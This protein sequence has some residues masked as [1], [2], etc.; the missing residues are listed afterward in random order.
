VS[1]VVISGGTDGIGKGIAH[2][3]LTRGDTV[4]IIGRDHGK[5]TDLL[6]TAG[7]H[8]TR[9]RAVF[10]PADLSLVSENRRV[11][12]EI[13]AA[14]PSID[15]LVLCARHYQSARTETSE[16]FEYNF[17]LLYLSR[18]LLSHG[19]AETLGRASRPSIVNLAGPGAV[20]H[21]RWDDLQLRHGYS[22]AAALMQAGGIANDLLAVDFTRHHPASGIRYVLVNPGTT[23]TSFAGNYDK[24]TAAQVE[25][26]KRAGKPVEQAVAPIL[27]R[28]DTPPDEL[29]SAYAG[30]R[31]L[32]LEGTSFDEASAMRLYAITETLL[33]N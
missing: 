31:P 18:Y 20:P 27:E 19:L 25:H 2:A 17:A 32:R 13:T 5:G 16:G 8:D 10:V 7:Q 33:G 24:T 26:M 9:G 23:S 21:I 29:L 11:I 15:A 12:A 28:I 6:R 14:F 22:G 3:R 1:V 30:H 4:V